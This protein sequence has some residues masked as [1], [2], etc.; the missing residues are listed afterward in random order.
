MPIKKSIYTPV[1]AIIM[2]CATGTVFSQ[3]N[4]PSQQVDQSAEI[5]QHG[6]YQAKRIAQPKGPRK[7]KLEPIYQQGCPPLAKKRELC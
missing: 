6:N 4:N 2:I 5:R 1:T 7:F 3:E